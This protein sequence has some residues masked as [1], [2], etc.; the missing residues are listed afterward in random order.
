M[1]KL[2][3]LIKLNIL[4]TED[5]SVKECIRSLEKSKFKMVLIKKKNNPKDIIGTITDGDIRR[6]FI[7]GYNLDSKAIQIA[8]KKYYFSNSIMSSKAAHNFMKKKVIK[9]LPIL[10]IGNKLIGIYCLDFQEITNKKNFIL[11]MA[12]GYGTRLRPFTNDKPKPMLKIDGKPILHHIIDNA[13]LAGFSNFLIST[14][15]KSEIIQSYFKNGNKFNVNID[16][17]KENKPLGTA[18]SLKY[19]QKITKLPF[20]V[21][22]GDMLTKLNYNDLINFH[23]NNKSL[24]TMAYRKHSY[25]N[26]YGVVKIKNYKIFSVEEKPIIDSFINTGLYVFDPKICKYIPNRFINMDELIEKLRNKK[27]FFNAFPLHEDWNDIGSKEDF[28]IMRNNKIL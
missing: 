4:L 10:D 22:N 23:L 20:V 11:I 18:G 14:H 28:Y 25:Q 9:H 1:I 5:C 24:C 3:E 13:K 7:K 15:Y 19:L 2:K 12:G 8:N 26:P 6:A 27:I 16:Y 21:T 17:I